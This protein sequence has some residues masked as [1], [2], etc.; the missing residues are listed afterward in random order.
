LNTSYLLAKR[1]RHS[2]ISKSN[3]SARIIKIAILAV[4]IGIASILVAVV[5]GR[6]LQKAI[7]KKTAAFNGHLVISTFENN[8]SQISL[9]PFKIDNKF[10]SVLDS[11]EN[12]QE[13]QKVAYK[14]GLIKFNNNYEGI[15]L[16]GIDSSFN[17][18]IFSEF[19]IQGRF[20]NLL[21]SNNNEII[22]S[23]YILKRLNLNLD[24]ELI[25]YFKRDNSQLIPNQRKYKVVGVYESNFSDFDEVYV[26]GSLDQ[27]RGL[28]NWVNDEVGAIEV[29]LNNNN[30]NNDIDTADKLYKALPFNIDVTTLKSKFGNIFQWI[31]LFDLNILIILIIMMFVGVINIAT[32]LLILIFERSSMIGLLKTIGSKDFEIQKIFFWIGFQIIAKGVV[33]GN[34]I[35][36][37][38]YFSQKYFKWIRLDPLTYYVNVAP[39]ELNFSEWLFINLSLI[40]TCLLLLWLPTKIINGISP[41]QN[42]RKS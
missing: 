1:I 27:I 6:G 29:F 24:D 14:A 4:T 41:S 13:Y 11:L 22:V 21:K 25:G 38:F 28:N 12:I 17:R 16:K 36:L 7:S 40:F 5:T 2:N 9:N 3:V 10:F 33:F 34:V 23:N 15:I 37:G 18:S 20:P 39:V 42:I 19:L 8:S 30:N 32:A 26:L 31:A 35:A